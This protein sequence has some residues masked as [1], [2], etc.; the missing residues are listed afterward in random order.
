MYLLGLRLVRSS[1]VVALDRRHERVAD[2]GQQ[3]AGER[4]DLVLRDELPV[5]RLGRRGM[6]LVVFGDQLELRGARLVARL[7]E[8]HLDAFVHVL[9]RGRED[10]AQRRDE[11]DLHGIGRPGGRRGDQTEDDQG[12]DED[13]HHGLLLDVV[14]VR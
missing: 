10:A 13:A 8:R 5:L 6:A 4:V 2:V 14:D 3:H 12:D 1:G 11:S 7:L 9:A